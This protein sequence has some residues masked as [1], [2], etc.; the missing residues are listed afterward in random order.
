MKGVKML[1]RKISIP[2]IIIVATVV[3]LVVSINQPFQRAEAIEEQELAV[4]QQPTQELQQAV[5][6]EQPSIADTVA[7]TSDPD[8]PSVRVEEPTDLVRVNEILKEKINASLLQPGWVQVT[9]EYTSFIESEATTTV[10]ENGQVIPR[11]YILE[12]WLLVAED[13]TIT[14]QYIR[15][16]SLSGEEYTTTLYSKDP[17]WP[18][19]ETTAL[20]T[21][22]LPSVLETRALD[23]IIA[24]GF[25]GDTKIEYHEEEGARVVTITSITQFPRPVGFNGWEDAKVVEFTQTYF[26]DW[27]TGLPLRIEEKITREDGSQMMAG[28]SFY[29]AS[30]AIEIPTDVML[31]MKVTG[32]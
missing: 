21:L 32:D 13:L 5:Q 27:E 24:M 19:T 29:S 10:P 4:P 23:D 18:T 12:Q 15:G 17:R 16:T 22:D 3:V 14:V 1:S 31:R 25:A 6:E 28:V 2:L 7:P 8:L 20:D 11:D 26:Y 9:K 30:Q